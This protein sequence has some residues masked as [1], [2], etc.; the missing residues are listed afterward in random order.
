[1]RRK[2]REK[3]AVIDSF[4]NDNQNQSYNRDLV[5]KY[6]DIISGTI[7]PCNRVD[8]ITWN[9][10]EMDEVY[11]KINNCKS[12][13]GD[14][15]L[16][17]T[18]HMTSDNNEAF[19]KKVDFF[20]SHANDRNDIWYILSRLGKQHNSYYFPLFINSLEVFQIPNIGYYRLMRAALFLSVIPAIV[21]MNYSYLMFTLFIAL[22][23]IVIYTVQKNKYEL[24]LD[25]LGS[26]LQIMQTARQIT[27]SRSLCYEE[28]FG[29]LGDNVNR[30]RKLILKISKIQFRASS[31]LYGDAL[32][33]L[34]SST[35]GVTLWDFIQYDKVLRELI[36]H[37]KELMELYRTI[38]EIDAAI[39]VASFRKRRKATISGKSDI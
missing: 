28:E 35:F 17:S 19:R 18:L 8:E 9:D 33:L 32:T 20:T 13:A 24:Y 38:G 2:E 10:L 1:M 6:W 36:G 4:H 22:T 14:Q 5:E 15:I 37:Q 34:E 27:D 3:K 11:C 26:V 16:F 25:M 23:N 39:A 21:Y 31:N 12:F 7:S 29:D 30:F